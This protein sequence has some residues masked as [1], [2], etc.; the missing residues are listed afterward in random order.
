MTLHNPFAGETP[1]PPAGDDVILKYTTSDILKLYTLYGPDPREAMKVEPGTNRISGHFWTTLLGRAEMHDPHVLFN[2]LKVGLKQR[3][4]ERLV[5]LKRPAEWWDD[6]PFSFADTADIITSGL[7]WSRWGMTPDQ[8]A[9][10]MREQ[11]ARVREEMEG[12]SALE[13][14]PMATTESPTSSA[15]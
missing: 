5:P 11:A 12:G 4:G 6:L 7:T 15:S 3:D 8:L 1:F 9:D 10:M 13:N 14:P 2:L